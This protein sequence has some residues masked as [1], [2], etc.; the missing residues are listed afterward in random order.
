MTTAVD[1]AVDAAY[2]WAGTSAL[3]RGVILLRA[4]S[5]LEARGETLRGVA[6]LR[7]FA[8]EG[9]QPI[10]EVY[11]SANPATLLYTLHVPLWKI[12]P[13]LVYGN[14]AV[15]KPAELTPLTATLLVE[16]LAEAGLPSGVLNLV[17]GQGSVIGPALTGDP[18]VTGVSFTGSNAVGRGIARTV[19]ERGGKVQLE[20]GGKNS[21]VVLADADLDQAADLT[22]QGAMLSTGQKCTATS[23]AIVERAVL[24]PFTWKVMARVEALVVGDPTDE[25]THVGPLASAAQRDTVRAYLDLAPREGAETL[26]GGILL[27][28]PAYNGGYFVRPHRLRQRAS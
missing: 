13:A 6:I 27:D 20:L 14:T 28:G 19:G 15:F 21:V 17:V 1:A 22:V 8:S 18:R 5:L 3:A 9:A 7:Y 10:G 11:P 12:A 25:R 4:A 2:G 16:I 23:R 26:A 24:E